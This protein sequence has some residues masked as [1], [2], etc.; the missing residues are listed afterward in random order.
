MLCIVIFHLLIICLHMYSSILSG[1]MQQ[2]MASDVQ[3]VME[4]RD[5]KAVIIYTVI[6][7]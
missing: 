1:E 2:S 4:N 6:I 3:R 5:P 7:A